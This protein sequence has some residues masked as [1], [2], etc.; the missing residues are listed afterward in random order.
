MISS[1]RK[2][3]K[4]KKL[5]KNKDTRV[6]NEEVASVFSKDLNKLLID[7]GSTSK[8]KIKLISEFINYEEVAINDTKPKE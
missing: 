6:H 7:I 1:L 2:T 8:L 5:F 3:F 4:V